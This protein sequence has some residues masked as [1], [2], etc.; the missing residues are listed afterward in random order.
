MEW[1]NYRH[2]LYFWLVARAGSLARASAELRLAQS[3]VSKQI[4][5]FEHMVGH[6]LFAK[7]GRR[8]VLTES[9]TVVFRYAD[10]IFGL[11]REML[12]TLRDRPVGRPLRV[13]V[14]IA[15]VVP[16]LIAERVLAPALKLTGPVRLVCREDEPDRL[17]ADL[18]LHELDVILTDA[19][20]SP[21]VKV[22]A[23]SHLLG[24]SEIVFFGRSD[25]A[26]K[27]RRK[28]PASLHGAPVLLPTENTVLRRSLDQWFE[29]QGVRPN[30]VGE[31][32]DNALLMVFGLR[33]AGLFPAAAV[34]AREVESQYRVRSIG[35]V[36]EVRERLYAVTV[37]RR[38]KHPVVSAICEMAKTLVFGEKP[39]P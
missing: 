29:A 11:G 16:K 27:Y 23:F 33:G 26:T 5:L 6:D 12:D 21:N 2:L 37:E 1:L 15:D 38:I 28:Y 10:E 35:K 7:S 13:T 4:H 20:A 30:V 14:G 18:A 19:P 32:E 9:G 34:I 25:L 36:P 22:R 3:T 39:P 31:F 17:L 24:E 8:L